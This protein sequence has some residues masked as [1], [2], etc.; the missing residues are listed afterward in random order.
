VMFG[1][2]RQSFEKEAHSWNYADSQLS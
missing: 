2:L 1:S